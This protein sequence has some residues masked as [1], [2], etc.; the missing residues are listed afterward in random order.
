MTPEFAAEGIA[1]DVMRIVQQARRDAGLDVS[2]RIRLTIGAEGPVGD[3]V[4]AHAGFLAA[5]RLAVSLEVF[6]LDQVSGEAYPL[7]GAGIVKPAFTRAIRR[8][9]TPERSVRP[10]DCRGHGFAGDVPG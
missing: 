5:E 7:G 3:A 8:L 1:R 6:P 10:G 2:D 4:R 9:I